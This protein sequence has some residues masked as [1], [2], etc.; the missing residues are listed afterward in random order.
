MNLRFVLSGGP[1]AGKTTVL[2]ALAARGYHSVPESARAIIQARLE[3]GLAPRPTPVE[4]AR[5]I[6][7][8]DI[9]HY[10]T[11][12]VTDKPVFFDRGVVDALGMLHQSGALPQDE[13]ARYLADYRY[14][15]VVFML[16]PWRHIY[17]NDAERD[18][19]F[20]ESVQIFEGLC[21]WYTQCHYH[22][23]ELPRRSV[24]EQVAFVLKHIQEH[25]ND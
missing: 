22:V 21:Q 2:A 18:Q 24:D 15:P 11:T 13:K 19:T 23:L 20:A 9:I 17:H 25:S 7:H 10:R 14:N 6:L 12:Q 8:R 1:G 4:F 16:P 5:E 3:A